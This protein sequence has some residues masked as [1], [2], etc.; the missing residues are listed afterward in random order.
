MATNGYTQIVTDAYGNEHA[1]H[2]NS[3]TGG[4]VLKHSGR[5]DEYCPFCHDDRDYGR[6]VEYSGEAFEIRA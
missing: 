5:T 2:I 1:L 3:E 4:T 6:G